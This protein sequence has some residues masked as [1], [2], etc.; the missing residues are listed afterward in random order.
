MNRSGLSGRSPGARVKST[1]ITQPQPEGV[2]TGQNS[3][4]ALS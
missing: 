2:A 4:A 1:P 3:N